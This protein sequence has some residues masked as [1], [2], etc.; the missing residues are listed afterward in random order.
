M[1]KARMRKKITGFDKQIALHMEK[2]AKA[3]AEGNQI[4]MDY[5]AKE[6]SN[7]ETQRKKWQ[8]M[9]KPKN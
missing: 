3:A 6:I 4:G 1:G 5:W 9:T 8:A 7:F 2:L